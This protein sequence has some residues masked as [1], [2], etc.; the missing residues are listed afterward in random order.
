M[1]C[2]LGVVLRWR[3]RLAA[4][5]E[6]WHKFSETVKERAFDAGGAVPKVADKRVSFYKGL[7]QETLPSFLKDYS[8]ERSLIIHID[9]D[10]YS[11][12][13]Y[14]LTQ[15]DQIAKPGTIIIFDEFPDL[16]HEFRALEDYCAAYMR[17]YDVLGSTHNDVQIAI[18][19]L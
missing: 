13:L 17:N 6:D 15:I 8:G 18:Q 3:I 11:A 4:L 1:S 12:S 16:L 10:L 9:C 7:F 19:M 2:S 5:P 14:V